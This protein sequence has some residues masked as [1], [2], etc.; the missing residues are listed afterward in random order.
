MIY[1]PGAGHRMSTFEFR[2]AYVSLVDPDGDCHMVGFADQE[3]GA[4]V[5]LVLSRD[6]QFDAADVAHGMDTYH[7]EW[8]GEATSGYG[9]ILSVALQPKSVEVVFS[10]EMAAALGGTEKLRIRFELDERE[11]DTLRKELRVI[12]GTPFVLEYDA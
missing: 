9:G 1:L 2:A 12:F 8:C 11:Y 7:V 5:Y 3:F 10:S 4:K 6:F